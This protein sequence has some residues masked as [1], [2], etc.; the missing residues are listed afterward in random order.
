MRDPLRCFDL[1][2]VGRYPSEN[3]RRVER[4]A[5]RVLL[6]LPKSTVK[7]TRDCIQIDC[8]GEKAS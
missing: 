8:G 3:S 5:G 1:D 2:P 6:L 7:R 4:N